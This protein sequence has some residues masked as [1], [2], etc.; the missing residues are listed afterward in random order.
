MTPPAHQRA[1]LRSVR[2]NAA[3][4]GA[5]LAALVTVLAVPA[6]ARPDQAAFV[7]DL[8]YD[9]DGNRTSVST[10]SGTD[11]AEVTTLTYDL[12]GQVR[13]VATPAYTA[14]VG[15]LPG[16][17]GLSTPLSEACRFGWVGGP[18]RRLEWVVRIA[19]PQPAVAGARR[20]P[21]D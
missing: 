17:A 19:M 10:Q 18:R 14:T 3:L 13:T 11:P 4:L 5:L 1:S 8:G 7:L 2:P 16:F 12:R 6:D 15:E 9:A 21:N 20:G